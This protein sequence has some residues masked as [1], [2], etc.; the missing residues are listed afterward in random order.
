MRTAIMERAI[1]TKVRFQYNGT[2]SAEDLYDLP[3]PAL[4]KIYKSLKAEV[5]DDDD[6]LLEEKTGAEKLL[7]LKIAVVKHVFNTLSEEKQARLD[8]AAIMANNKKIKG[9]IAQKKDEQLLNLPLSELEKLI[10]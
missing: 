1:R 9:I 5:K 7:D 2:I 8:A 10:V 4:N 3:L 6:S